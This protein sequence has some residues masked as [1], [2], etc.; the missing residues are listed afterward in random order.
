M[1]R[2]ARGRKRMTR[3][4]TVRRDPNVL[5]IPR[6]L[7]SKL[8]TVLT[9]QF[10]PYSSGNTSYAIN[11]KELKV[12]L[13]SIDDPDFATGGHRPPL[14]SNY[15]ALYD[16]YIVNSCT[17]HARIENFG[18][19]PISSCVLAMHD[20]TTNNPAFPVNASSYDV[21]AIGPDSRSP[22]KI[23]TM[24]SGSHS[25][26]NI[27]KTFYPKKII[28]RTYYTS[29]NFA[30]TTTADPLGLLVA[31]LIV[32]NRRADTND[33]G[34]YADVSLTYDITFYDRN[35]VEIADQD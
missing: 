25:V 30:G 32:W 22:L 12:K 9:Y 15:M 4:K 26:I 13:N 33:W 19:G 5:Y 29:T 21:N 23:A 18:G 6:G 8:R 10:A 27:N 31:D 35:E 24:S 17:V 20:P 14:A 7:P 16:K 11:Y 1:P 2:K 34:Y 3:K 28:G